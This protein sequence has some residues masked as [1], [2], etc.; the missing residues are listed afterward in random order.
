M[1]RLSKILGL[2]AR[3]VRKTR[4]ANL[5]LDALEERKVLS[6]TYGTFEG[7]NWEFVPAA[8]QKPAEL[9]FVDRQGNHT[10][11][12]QDQYD[13]NDG[14]QRI[15]GLTWTDQS[16]DSSGG[17]NFT[18]GTHVNIV[19]R[20][21]ARENNFNNFSQQTMT[22]LAHSSAS[23]TTQTG[24]LDGMTW[25]YVP[26]AGL[27]GGGTTNGPALADLAQVK[28]LIKSE[29]PSTDPSNPR[30]YEPSDNQFIDNTGYTGGYG[31]TF[32]SRLTHSAG[33]WEG[34][35]YDLVSDPT[36]HASTLYWVNQPGKSRIYFQP[37]YDNNDMNPQ[38][39]GIQWA[40]QSTDDG[41]G[42][43]FPAGTDLSKVRIVL[44]QR[45]GD[46]TFVNG[47]SFRMTTVSR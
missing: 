15:N 11:D 44:F 39:N 2:G 3:P 5:S 35:K 7:M 24:T 22:T 42:V 46:N 38:I 31:L 9:I 30:H 37:Q 32:T 36:T 47:T 21:G 27:H 14:P 41:G 20:K 40:N 19:L 26:E 13:G 18:P 16:T 33:T 34:M 23:M 1:N 45:A 6:T 28:I 4:R 10:I 25:T 12:F 43:N 29:G 8:S 17:I